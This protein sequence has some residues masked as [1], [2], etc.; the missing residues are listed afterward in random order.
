MARR[1]PYKISRTIGLRKNQ[2][3]PYVC[4]HTNN[5]SNPYRSKFR[6]HRGLPGYSGRDICLGNY[7]EEEIAALAVELFVATYCMEYPDLLL[8][9]SALF[10]SCEVNSVRD[11]V[12]EYPVSATDNEVK[13]YNI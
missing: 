11:L 5:R 8:Q 1:P 3:F 4:C 6:I 2:L 10:T 12:R 7:E 9:L 13:L